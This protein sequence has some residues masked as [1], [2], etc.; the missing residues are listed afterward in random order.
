MGQIM[1]LSIVLV[2]PQ[3]LEAQTKSQAINIR[4]LLKFLSRFPPI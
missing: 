1:K 4:G 3:L 2:S